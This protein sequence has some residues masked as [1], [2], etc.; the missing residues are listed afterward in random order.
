MYL[1][2]DLDDGDLPD[3][4]WHR[5][6]GLRRYGVRNGCPPDPLPG[7]AARARPVA[8]DASDARSGVVLPLAPARPD[9]VRTSPAGDDPTDRS[10]HGRAR[11]CGDQGRH[12]RSRD[13]RRQW[14][15]T[16]SDGSPSSGS[17]SPSASMTTA[18]PVYVYCRE[19]QAVPAGR[20]RHGGH[21]HRTPVVRAS[22][23]DGAGTELNER[24]IE[25]VLIERKGSPC[26]RLSPRC[27]SRSTVT[28]PG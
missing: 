13:R 15:G 19:V 1:D 16:T 23:G 11:R 18:P 4:V 24:L 14:D 17:R 22:A 9:R 7:C 3:L 28:A 8:A 6:R 26:K 20:C 27:P 12:R 5:P 2:D 10:G 25:K 21:R